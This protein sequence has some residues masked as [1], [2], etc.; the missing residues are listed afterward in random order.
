ME[1]FRESLMGMIYVTGPNP[2]SDSWEW[3][4]PLL[5]D[6]N[7]RQY[8]YILQGVSSLR[9]LPPKFRGDNFVQNTRATTYDCAHV[10]TRMRIFILALK[11]HP[12]SIL[13]VWFARPTLLQRASCFVQSLRSIS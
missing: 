6:V 10:R 5:N 11:P 7:P 12:H 4:T 8:Y 9:S 3:F 2:M 13:R 1:N